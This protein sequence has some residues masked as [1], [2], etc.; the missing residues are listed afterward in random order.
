MYFVRFSD[1]IV[2]LNEDNVDDYLAY[3]LI[4]LSDDIR[5]LLYEMNV[6]TLP[7]FL[8]D[9]NWPENIKKDLLEQTHK[10]MAQLTELGSMRK[11]TTELYVPIDNFE[12]DLN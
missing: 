3:G 4:N 1:K 11:G 2:E 5:T 10:F 8:K 6:Y 12:E 7:K 9:K